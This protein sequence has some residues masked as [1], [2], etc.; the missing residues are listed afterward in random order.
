MRAGLHTRSLP[1]AF[2]LPGSQHAS[3]IVANTLG[4]ILSGSPAICRVKGCRVLQGT[5]PKQ[6]IL[7]IGYFILSCHCWT[8]ACRLHTQTL[9]YKCLQVAYTDI[10]IVG[11]IS[12][13]QAS[14]FVGAV[15]AGVHMV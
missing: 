14:L 12:E 3:S 11:I 8:C 5:V 9:L 6:S 7:A 4:G 13:G 15:V 2:A 10:Y 1:W